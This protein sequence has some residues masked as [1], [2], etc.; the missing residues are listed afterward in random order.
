MMS[1]VT[2][3]MLISGAREKRC[4]QT[5]IC[6]CTYDIKQTNSRTPQAGHVLLIVPH[7][8]HGGITVMGILM[9]PRMVLFSW[10]L[11]KMSGLVISS[12]QTEWMTMA[13]MTTGR[14]ALHTLQAE[15]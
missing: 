9:V 6:V 10:S 1:Y 7:M 5:I 3:L 12:M 11:Q 13:R 2:S 14:V 15:D 4:E 8:C